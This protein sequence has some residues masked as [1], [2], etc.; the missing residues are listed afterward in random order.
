[1]EEDPEFKTFLKRVTKLEN[2]I[3]NQLS[4][5]NFNTTIYAKFN[6]SIE[7]ID[8][9]YNKLLHEK[10]AENLINDKIFNLID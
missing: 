4:Y 7:N 9:Q 3:K 6:I 2:I 10:V 5:R 8:E 1:M